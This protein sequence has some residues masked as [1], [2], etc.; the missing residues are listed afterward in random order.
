M[1]HYSLI[2]PN[3]LIGRAHEA[4]VLE[5]RLRRAVSGE[6]QVAL[7]EG[8]TGIGKTCLLEEIA[9]RASNLGL[10]VFWGAVEQLEH[11]RP[12]GVVAEALDLRPSSSDPARVHI[13][14]LLVGGKDEEA[15]IQ[16]F[17]DAEPRIRY[18][19]LEAILELIENLAVK[20][21]V[22]LVLE[23]LHWAD[24]SSLLTLRVLARR[25]SHLSLVL[26]TSFRPWPHT[27]EFDAVM[28]GLVNQGALHFQLNPLS[29]ES[30]DA[31]VAA[32]MGAAPSEN[33]REQLRRA[34]GNPLFLIEICRALDSEGLLKFV[35]GR[36]EMRP[37]NLPQS[38]NLILLRRLSYLPKDT[39]QNVA[40][41]VGVG[42]KL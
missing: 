42:I 24:S 3:A 8:E 11:T 22:L 15:E 26:L 9:E 13:A 39:L 10:Q 38:L 2:V 40:G 18:L 36:V 1:S 41:S 4:A 16:S 17:A 34:K 33:L 21:P 5:Q 23:D 20:A 6:A 25:L 14:R 30:V 12:F 7:L 35:D 31:L 27:S 32:L 29:D 28:E 19:I 37:V